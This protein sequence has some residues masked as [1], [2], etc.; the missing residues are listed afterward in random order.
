MAE[1]PTSGPLDAETLA[2]YLDGRLSPAERAVVEAEV[3]AHPDLYE[4]FVSTMRVA[5]RAAQGHGN[6][7]PSSAGTDDVGAGADPPELVGDLLLGD[8]DRGVQSLE[9]ALADRPETPATRPRT[10]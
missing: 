2:A 5:E 4:W 3:A 8:Y 7:G 1:Q 10:R 6:P 9:L